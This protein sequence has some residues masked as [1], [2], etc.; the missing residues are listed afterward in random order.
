[1]GVAVT[2]LASLS[3]LISVAD[4]AYA[5]SSG[6]CINSTTGC[7][8]LKVN[9]NITNPPATINGPVTIWVRRKVASGL[10]NGF[11]LDGSG[12]SYTSGGYVWGTS[13]DDSTCA[14]AP[15]DP[16]N[17]YD[18]EASG[19]AVG[20]TATSINLCS[21]AAPKATGGAGA[22][23]KTVTLSVQ[24]AGGVQT[25]G[26]I[27]GSFNVI[28]LAGNVRPCDASDHV[29]F[30]GPTNN[31]DVTLT[32]GTVGGKP[33][34]IFNSGL[35]FAP[36]TY[37]VQINCTANG[38]SGPIQVKGVKVV[39][40]KTTD[41]GLNS[42]DPK[43]NNCGL[44]G[45]GATLTATPK[46]TTVDDTPPPDCD[47]G[48][49][50]WAICPIIHA[51][52]DIIDWIRDSVIV[53]LLKEAPLTQQNDA[54]VYSIWASMRNVSSLF[55]ILVFFLVIIGTA[56]GFD[57]YTIKKVL[58][59][60]VA[61]AIL[62]PLSWYICALVIDL[63]NVIGGGAVALLSPIIG[64]P[65]IDFDTAIGPLFFGATGILAVGLVYFAFTTIG[66]GVLVTVLLGVLSAF[67]TLVGR[68]ILITL[69]IILSP[70]A[71]LA[72]VL[73]N[74]EKWFSRWWTNFLRLVMIYPAFMLF[75]EAGR[76]FSATSTATFSA[77][78]ALGGPLHAAA[79]GMPAFAAIGPEALKQL[80]TVG[81]LFGLWFPVIFFLPL[82]EKIQ[83]EAGTALTKGINKT[84]NA[85][86]SRYGKDSDRA[87]EA[88]ENRQRNS[89]RR[90]R[91]F[92]DQ[93]KDPNVTG[94]AK[95][96]AQALERVNARRAGI[97]KGFKWTGG[98]NNE[99][100]ELKRE[101]AYSKAQAEHGIIGANALNSKQGLP[102]ETEKDRE[103]AEI[104][105][106]QTKKR[107]ERASRMGIVKDQDDM[108][109]ENSD[110][111]KRNNLK[112]YEAGVANSAR[113]VATTRGTLLGQR[114]AQ[115]NTPQ[116][117]RD[118]TEGAIEHGEVKGNAEASATAGGILHGANLDNLRLEK[119]NAARA[120]AGMAPITLE[121]AHQ[122][123][124]N[125][126]V[127]AGISKEGAHLLESEIDVNSTNSKD[128]DLDKEIQARTAATGGGAIT[129]EEARRLRMGNILKAESSKKRKA[130]I[131]GEA[132]NR[133]YN[134]VEDKA[135]GPET[136]RDLLESGRLLSRQ[137]MIDERQKRTSALDVQKRGQA[138]TT[139]TLLRASRDTQAR[140]F[141]KAGQDQQAIVNDINNDIAAE[142]GKVE[143][144]G[145]A[146]G[147][148]LSPAMAQARAEANVHNRRIDNAGTSALT[149]GERAA[150]ASV[151]TEAGVVEDLD[152]DIND[153]I[154]D[155]QRAAKLSSGGT[156]LPAHVAKSLAEANVRERR[157]NNSG[158]TARTKAS[159]SSAAEI[160]AEAGVKREVDSTLEDALYDD[161]QKSAIALGGTPLPVDVARSR[162]QAI[163]AARAGT[164]AA[165]DARAA[166]ERTVRRRELGD[167]RNTAEG[168]A[169]VAS[170]NEVT[171]AEGSQ[172]S[173]RTQIN[174]E[175]E[176]IQAA[177]PLI[178]K[179]E[180]QSR[181]K[182]AVTRK[183]LNTAGNA[184]RLAAEDK[185]RRTNQ[186]N[187]GISEGFDKRVNDELTANPGN[188]TGLSA[189]E[190]TS[191]A[192]AQVTQRDLDAVG[193]NAQMA[194]SNKFTQER[195]TDVGVAADLDKAV[196]EEMKRS[197]SSRDVAERAVLDRSLTN[198]GDTTRE[199]AGIANREEREKYAGIQDKR[200]SAIRREARRAAGKGATQAQVD[201][202]MATATE[203][204][205]TR[206]LVN[207]G[208]AS[209]RTAGRQA[210]KETAQ[211]QG[212]AETVA[213]ERLDEA[214]RLRKEDSTLTPSQALSQAEDSAFDRNLGALE[215]KAVGE[216]AD[217]A[218][219]ET[220]DAIGDTKG[221]EAQ[222]DEETDA[223]AASIDA[224][225]QA[226][227]GGSGYVVTNAHRQQ[228]REN[229][230]ARV[231]KNIG[232]R[233][234]ENSGKAAEIA[235]QNARIQAVK[236]DEGV[237]TTYEAA[238]EKAPIEAARNAASKAEYERAFAAARAAGKDEKAS[239]L[240]AEGL[241]KEAGDKAAA[242]AGSGGKP[243]GKTDK[244][245]K[246]IYTS[247]TRDDQVRAGITAQGVAAKESAVR[248]ETTAQANVIGLNQ[249]ATAP[250]ALNASE[251]ITMQ[252]ENV[253]QSLAAQSGAERARYQLTRPG[254]TLNRSYQEVEADA[255]RT[256][257]NTVLKGLLAD[258]QRKELEYPVELPYVQAHDATGTPLFIKDPA[259]GLDTTE[260]L[261]EPQWQIDPA[262]G[263]P[264]TETDPITGQVSRIPQI[265]MRRDTIAKTDVNPDSIGVMSA[266]VRKLLTD[267]RG[268]Q[269]EDEAAA[270][271]INMS[272]TNAGTRE[273]MRI[274]EE[275]FGATDT[276]NIDPSALG[277][278]AREIWEL[279]QDG[280]DIKSKP[281]FTIPPA[282]IF[283]GYDGKSF[284]K[285]G[286]AEK[287]KYFDYASKAKQAN[288]YREA[289]R[290][291]YSTLTNKQAKDGLNSDDYQAM[292]L[293]LQDDEARQ[294]L[295]DIEKDSPNGK[296]GVDVIKEIQREGV[297]AGAEYKFSEEEAEEY[298]RTT[299][300]AENAA[301]IAA[302]QQ[303]KSPVRIGDRKP[304]ATDPTGQLILDPTTNRPAIDTTRVTVHNNLSPWITAYD[305][306]VLAGTPPPRRPRP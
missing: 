203:T 39:A 296:D 28:D 123:R 291:I 38:A 102:T 232:R 69:F 10:D 99:S 165:D 199:Q 235:G 60:L 87:K 289:A 213:K 185:G 61:G 129:L 154:I 58:P 260:P 67:I 9:L 263:A 303:P 53:P 41:M 137:G 222:I 25:K 26:G 244:T 272:K 130:G 159:R 7:I 249:A 160:G 144:A 128:D 305:A 153:E 184:T 95:K 106:A 266:R 194:G 149:K 48:A 117:S 167:I 229:V 2:L 84:R 40:G 192:T 141:A 77:T 219:K 135:G 116:N 33:A 49:F 201:A 103:R 92:G 271:L 240:E 224:E 246:P 156:P 226:L 171:D 302:G 250:N 304:L 169:A 173:A 119:E 80:G 198:L 8:T 136:A 155:I 276:Q 3:S 239:A 200:K 56:A 68:K 118:I 217:Q 299:L 107:N 90:A 12:T 183:N 62:V 268:P 278:R 230:R 176:K 114:K 177:N 253:T 22:L 234:A 27:K 35:V 225:A 237:L 31:V 109:G 220:R 256:Q 208:I 252:A 145:V 55:F 150:A 16:F 93:A 1:M 97:P 81:G 89:I 47:A 191:K 101:A 124:M 196:S 297:E 233:V 186:G 236:K 242:I 188:Y 306:A 29:E 281:L 46:P 157:L 288:I 251:R 181:A 6:Q 13:A 286:Y 212:I 164:A 147:V 91:K 112:E 187:I 211:R 254:T 74:T 17:Q 18:I 227:A 120:A 267:P 221:R 133:T 223:A 134:E 113:N 197:N 280:T 178:S 88:A 52:T 30:T 94:F 82:Y 216:A 108:G 205:D 179:D 100:R 209:R 204:V 275:I 175:A 111:M 140:S 247:I 255:M 152:N 265:T 214:R 210:L 195:N 170:R 110:A 37:D 202:Q 301:R 168:N 270:M 298:N 273:V 76:L 125:D 245:G 218:H 4:T 148:A 5:A 36:G 132:E 238:I 259:T 20:R 180:A 44:A 75:V 274:Q 121:Q 294:A 231:A 83:G 131:L 172:N 15:N 86:D 143:R 189:E 257:R 300:A 21:N 51:L 163:V 104:L 72:W 248:T 54:Q 293:F 258:A 14:N 174:E 78:A 63:S 285:S 142:R 243:T 284:I 73:P 283:D 45:G 262:T 264:L 269:H 70:F 79:L 182:I 23:V 228:A 162:A 193:K 207:A 295:Y 71:L 138:P 158:T 127:K 122:L 151:N 287:Y 59:H 206:N 98:T 34:S 32:D 11:T 146:A 215:T 42:C 96:R 105:M 115:L 24:A 277:G 166:G 261:M 65:K 161:I 292:W 85:A 50:T 66:L 57:N 139:E 279:V 190:A 241:A 43:A 126:A 19:G 64:S 290:N 282:A